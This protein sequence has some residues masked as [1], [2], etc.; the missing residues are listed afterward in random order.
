MT[1]LSNIDVL[2]AEFDY[3][4]EQLKTGVA[5][6]RNRRPVSRRRTGL[7]RLR[8]GGAPDAPPGEAVA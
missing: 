5:G 6:R 1:Y 4:T 7:A 8:R 3:R 2:N